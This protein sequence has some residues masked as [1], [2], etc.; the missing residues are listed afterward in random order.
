MA[1]QTRILEWKAK[2]AGGL[3]LPAGAGAG[4][5][6]TSDASGNGS[7]G[8]GCGAWTETT[9]SSKI[10]PFGEPFQTVRVRTEQGGAVARIRGVIIVKAGQTIAK[11]EAIITLPV[12]FRP[13]ATIVIYID[14]E[15]VPAVAQVDSSGV[16]SPAS[17]LAAGKGV[18]LDGIIFNL[19]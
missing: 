13:P 5:I 2:L 16:V 17:T 14:N 3:L 10:E 11:G 9:P 8:T 1:V 19:T 12:G 7:W 6:L 18:G 15:G 4:K